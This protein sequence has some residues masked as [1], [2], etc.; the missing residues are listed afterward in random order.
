M[1][2]LFFVLFT[3]FSICSFAQ[4]FDDYESALQH[5]KDWSKRVG[6][7]AVED[8]YS[9][10]KHLNSASLKNIEEIP[11]E[12]IGRIDVE[13]TWDYQYKGCYIGWDQYDGTAMVKAY[14]TPT[15]SGKFKTGNRGVQVL[16]YEPD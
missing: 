8:K 6:F 7:D 9:H 2:H 5:L 3:F 10:C 11:N 13:I 15:S 1:K 4:T 16:Y 12:I 14:I